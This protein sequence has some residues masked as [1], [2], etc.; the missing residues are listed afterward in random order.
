MKN[1]LKPANLPWFVLAAGAIGIALRFWLLATGIDNKGLLVPG[2]P[3]GILLWLLTA[4]VAAIVIPSCLPLVQANKYSF[5]FPAAPAGA[6]GEGAL[7]LGILAAAILSLQNFSDPLS[8]AT[9]II[10]FLSV[11]P[12]ILCALCRW[13]GMR[14]RF[15]LHGIV[16][17]FWILRLVSQYRIWSPEPQLQNYIF[18]LFA[19]VFMLLSCYQRTAFDAGLGN[20]RVHAIF[21]LL[22]AFFCCLSMI[23]S[24]DWFLYGTCGLWAIT[25]LCRMIPLPGWTLRLHKKDEDHDPS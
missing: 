15:F 23:D 5:N 17:I 6:V 9:A 22:A 16:C 2:H 3:A 11:P 21:H 24:R 7:A 14:P 13:N 8:A 25:D 10:G 1:F 4:V 19:N 20:R 12:L 18:Q